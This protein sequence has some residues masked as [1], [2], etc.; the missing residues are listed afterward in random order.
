M[1]I[2]KYEEAKSRYE[3]TKPIRGRAIECRPWGSRNRDWEQVVKE[4]I[5]GVTAYGAR[6]YQTN[7]VMFMPNGDVHIR[8]GGYN[9]PITAEYISARLPWGLESRKQ[10]GKLWIGGSGLNGENYPVDSAKGMVLKH[11]GTDERG[12][13]LYEITEKPKMQRVAVDREKSKQATLPTKPFKDYATIMLKLADGWI[14]DE[15]VR[16]HCVNGTNDYWGR[17]SYE[18]NGHTFSSYSLDGQMSTCVAQQVYEIICNATE[19]QYPKLLC[20]IAQGCTFE[21][22]RV[23]REEQKQGS[24]NYNHTIRIYE[25]KY[26]AKT[27]ANR[28]DYIVKKAVDVTKLVDVEAGKIYTKLA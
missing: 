12:K 25:R 17:S 5:D 20:M 19:D 21:E 2:R 8:N 27:V 16:Q 26:K 11:K 18:W 10:Y 22:S 28:V 7:V 4:D 13:D 24:N 9:T 15:L 6:L 14:L 1:S 23:I 3:N